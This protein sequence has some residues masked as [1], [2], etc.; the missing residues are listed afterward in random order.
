V[1]FTNY[2]ERFNLLTPSRK[3]LADET[4]AV[5]SGFIRLRWLTN[6]CCD[7][8]RLQGT[9]KVVVYQRGVRLIWKDQLMSLEKRPNLEQLVGNSPSD[10]THQQMARSEIRIG[11]RDIVA[12]M[13]EL[14]QRSSL[15]PE[16]TLT[17]RQKKGTGMVNVC[18]GTH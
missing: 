4:S 13:A 11:S 15:L 14:P 17:T 9:N 10:H 12:C 3:H 6:R 5:F 18:P 7:L 2:V 16:H 1:V 8:F